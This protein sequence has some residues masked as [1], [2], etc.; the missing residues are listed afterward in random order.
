M[1]NT[2]VL[3]LF[4][5]VSVNAF[6]APMTATLTAID[7]DPAALTTKSF[8]GGSITIDVAARRAALLLVPAQMKCPVGQVCP[9]F[10]RAAMNIALPLVSRRTGE[11][12]DIV[13]VAQTDNR[14]VDGVLRRLTIVDHSHN[15]CPG[16]RNRV[17]VDGIYE[18]DGRIH[19]RST[20]EAADGFFQALN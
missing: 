5:L 13:F 2:L 11:C 20:F 9:M 19:T 8:T 12:G 15:T 18:T 3:A 17:T 16:T 6:A 1:K 7:A 4:S 14:T 10:L